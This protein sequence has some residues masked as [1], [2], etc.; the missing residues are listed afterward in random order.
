MYKN[1]KEEIFPS[2][3]AKNLE[4]ECVENYNKLTGEAF[5]CSCANKANKENQK[6]INGFLG[7]KKK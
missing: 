2:K 1:T 3:N 5:L 6:I 4:L 7:R